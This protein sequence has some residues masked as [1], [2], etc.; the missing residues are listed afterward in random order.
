MRPVMVYNWPHGT[1]VDIGPDLASR[2]ADVDNV[3]AIKDSTPNLEQ[4]FET[5]KRVVGR[6]RVFG[7]L[8]GVAGA[9]VPAR[10]RR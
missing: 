8:M 3:V 7:P 2:I 10:A 1:S 9:R 4:F 6:V 5:T